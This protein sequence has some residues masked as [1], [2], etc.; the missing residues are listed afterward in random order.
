VFVSQPEADITEIAMPSELGSTSDVL[1]GSMSHSKCIISLAGSRYRTDQYTADLP[2]LL[3]MGQEYDRVTLQDIFSEQQLILA[4][5]QEM[6]TF[7]K[8]QVNLWLER[9]QEWKH[10]LTQDN[11][12]R[13]SVDERLQI[14]L[15]LLGQSVLTAPQPVSPP[16]T[17]S[18]SPSF[19]HPAPSSFAHPSFGQPIPSSFGQPVP[20]SFG[21]P[22]SSSFGQPVLSS[23]GQPVPQAFGHSVQTAANDNLGSHF[24]QYQ[25]ATHFQPLLRK[26][27]DL[28][29]LMEEGFLQEG[30]PDRISLLI[31]LK[32][33]HF[34]LKAWIHVSTSNYTL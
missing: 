22:V 8:R 24:G 26:A 33:N 28:Q 9:D 12:W 31:Q 29:A 16:Y 6:D 30:L 25:I 3:K 19:A 17:Q 20:S 5:Y 1:A 15:D 7:I 32:L 10:Q 23:F 34:V 14:I 21:Q 4:N 11:R 2:N 18:I 13:V 27:M